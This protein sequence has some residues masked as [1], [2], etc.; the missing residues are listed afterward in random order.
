MKRIILWLAAVAPVLTGAAPDD[1]GW[2]AGSSASAGSEP[3]AGAH[4]PGLPQPGVLRHSR[5]V[6]GIPLQLLV[7]AQVDEADGVR[8][9]GDEA[10]HIFGRT[11]VAIEGP[12]GALERLHKNAGLEPIA[13]DA[14]AFAVLRDAVRIWTLADGAF[15]PTAGAYAS[16]WPFGSSSLNHVPPPEE[17]ARRSPLVN[18]RQLV[19]DPAAQS[20]VLR[21]PGMRLALGDLPRGLALDKAMAW[22]REK[23]HGDAIMYA[24]GDLVVSGHKGGQRWMVGVQDPRGTG[25]FAALPVS[26][27]AVF[28]VGDYEQ[29]FFDRGRRYHHVLDPRTGLPAK[30]VRSLTVVAQSG[31]EAA[32]LSHAVFVMGPEKGMR[33]LERLPGIEAVMVDDRNRVLVTKGLANDIRYR[34]PTDGP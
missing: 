13:V 23:G 24:G 22:L 12:G 8:A 31:V 27:G 16:L 20:A 25:H 19:L 21:T 30:G 11:L 14:D 17:L 1:A 10:F 9:S 4:A 7:M 32:A 5:T 15:D 33:F 18:C 34:P 6:N 2:A 28:T 3:D 26:A 29:S